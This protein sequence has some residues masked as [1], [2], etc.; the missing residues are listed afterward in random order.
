MLY[1]FIKL[2]FKQQM[3]VC[4]IVSPV[5][6]VFQGF[7]INLL[8]QL[9]VM[10]KGIL[11]SKMFVFNNTPQV[12]VRPIIMVGAR[13]IVKNIKFKKFYTWKID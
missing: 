6:P 9:Q 11:S 2:I 8:F 3:R 13:W 12:I 4:C 7:K 5:G 1:D 10:I